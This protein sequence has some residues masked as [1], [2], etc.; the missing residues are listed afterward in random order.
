M[1]VVT[2]IP[3]VSKSKFVRNYTQLKLYAQEQDCPAE[4]KS[5]IWCINKWARSTVGMINT[6]HSST[7]AH[8]PT[9][10]T[11]TIQMAQ[12]GPS[13]AMVN[14]THPTFR[15]YSAPSPGCLET[16]ILWSETNGQA[17]REGAKKK[18]NSSNLQEVVRLRAFRSSWTF[19]RALDAR[20]TS[21]EISSASYLQLYS[22]FLALEA[23]DPPLRS[24][25]PKR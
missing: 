24:E 8:N 10:A 13:S 5:H 2:R 22:S 17:K 21:S 4:I 14:W 15:F 6:E 18:G 11:K 23:E 9:A 3:D 1:H 25:C 7:Q 19:S 12:G 16:D 20:N